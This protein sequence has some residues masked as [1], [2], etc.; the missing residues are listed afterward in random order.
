[1]KGCKVLFAQ[2]IHIRTTKDNSFGSFEKITFQQ[3]DL[4]AQIVHIDLQYL[5]RYI[6]RDQVTID[7]HPL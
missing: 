3:A 6:D 7:L 5:E 2:M 4:N 1:M